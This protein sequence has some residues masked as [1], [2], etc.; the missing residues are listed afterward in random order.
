MLRMGFLFLNT[1]SFDKN[2]QVINPAFSPGYFRIN[3][4]IRIQFNCA[5]VLEGYQEIVIIKECP[6]LES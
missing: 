5:L 4:N 1:L 3:R 2:R 6:L